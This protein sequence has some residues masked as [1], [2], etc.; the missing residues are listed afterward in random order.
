M[1]NSFSERQGITKPL[2]LRPDEMPIELRN[3]LWNCIKE[4]IDEFYFSDPVRGGVSLDR[5]WIISHLWDRF[6]KKSVDSLRANQF[7][8]AYLLDQI[9][10]QFYSLEWNRVYDLIEY[11][12]A[13]PNNQRTQFIQKVDQIFVDE[14]APYKIIDELVTPLVSGEEAIEVEKAIAGKYSIVSTHIK[15]ALEL[16]RKR[17]IADYENS[18]KESI[19]A[20][21]ALSKIILNK[22]NGTLGELVDQLKI[23]P[24]FKEALKKLYGWTSDEGGIRHSGKGDALTIDEKEARY[25]LIECSALVNYIIAKEGK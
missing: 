25:M 12:I 13:I 10:D 22:P 8:G 20:V 18:I 24:A 19:S 16:Y 1:T 4:Q 14:G 6:F 11:L 23:H 7:S 15:K 21:E 3:R 9:K 17:P 2:S 5:D